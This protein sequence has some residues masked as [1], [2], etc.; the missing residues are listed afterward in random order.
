MKVDARTV[1]PRALDRARGEKV[2][3]DVLRL[4]RLLL[5]AREVHQLGDQRRHLA[6]LLDDVVQEP[7]ALAGRQLALA[8]EH[9]DVGA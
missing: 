6:E 9:L 7:F 3:A 5:A 1:A 2:E 4:G 8:R